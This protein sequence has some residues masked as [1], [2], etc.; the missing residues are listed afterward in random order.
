[1]ASKKI[2]CLNIFF[3]CVLIERIHCKEYVLSKL[4]ECKRVPFEPPCNISFDYFVPDYASQRYEIMLETIYRKS[5]DIMRLDSRPQCVNAYREYL[6][7]QLFP[8]CKKSQS[9]RYTSLKMERWII[10]DPDIQRKCWK[11]FSSCNSRVASRFMSSDFF[12]CDHLT[13][14]P[15]GWETDRCVPYD[16]DKRCNRKY[17]KVIFN[18]SVTLYIIPSFT[19][20]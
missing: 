10:H 4:N 3:I 18:I 17:G 9:Q 15:L 7:A 20:S 12:L 13:Y 1:M 5:K 6:C 2:C 11:I 19:I 14:P 16:L 8:R